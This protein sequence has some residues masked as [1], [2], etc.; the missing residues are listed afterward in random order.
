MKKFKSR[1]FRFVLYPLEFADHRK[2]LEY[3]KSNYDCA[4]IEHNK[5]KKEDGEIKKAHTHVVISLPNAKW[6]GAIAKEMNL[7]EI[8]FQKCKNLDNALEWLIDYNAIKTELS[9]DG[10]Y[11][12]LKLMLQLYQELEKINRSNNGKI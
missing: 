7:P 1:M 12:S 4:F 11:G 9:L 3:I 10:V 2:A 8:Y 5:Y 6:N